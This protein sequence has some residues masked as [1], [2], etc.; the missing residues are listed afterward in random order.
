MGI[1]FALL[2]LWFKSLT[3]GEGMMI[4]GFFWSL[5]FK[6]GLLTKGSFIYYV[7]SNPIISAWGYSP[8]YS[9]SSNSNFKGVGFKE[10][11]IRLWGVNNLDC[12]LEAYYDLRSSFM[13]ELFCLGVA[14]DCCFCMV[15]KV[16]LTIT[17]SSMD[18]G[19]EDF[20]SWMTR[21]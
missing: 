17:L 4:N 15:T 10:C 5:F 7:S 11:L 19:E 18:S 16:F 21:A 8:F 20:L 12:S 9:V 1:P 14:F 3:T 6:A 13:S 2:L